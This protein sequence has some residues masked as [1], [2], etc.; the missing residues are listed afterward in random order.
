MVKVVR[1][2]TPFILVVYVA[3]YFCS[4]LSSMVSDILLIVVGVMHPYCRGILKLPLS[5]I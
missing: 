4:C 1:E 3:I 2:G 5:L